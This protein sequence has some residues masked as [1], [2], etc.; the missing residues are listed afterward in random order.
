MTAGSNARGKSMLAPSVMAA[1]SVPGQSISLG[2]EESH[3]AEP[4]LKETM[5]SV[6]ESSTVT[7]LRETSG[8]Q[9][10]ESPAS[11]KPKFW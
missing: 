11:E 5:V 3:T 9:R 2:W 8:M 10:L 6:L 4:N 1:V 7:N